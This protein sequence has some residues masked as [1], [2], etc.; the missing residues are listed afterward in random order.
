MNENGITVFAVFLHM[1]Y[2]GIY[3]LY[4]VPCILL[5]TLIVIIKYMS[6]NRTKNKNKAFQRH[7]G[8]SMA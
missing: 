8:A 3:T 5:Y 6:I 7:S 4:L 2:L 1:H